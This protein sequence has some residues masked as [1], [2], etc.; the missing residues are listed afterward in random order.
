MNTRKVKLFKSA[1]EFI[2]GELCFTHEEF[3]YAKRLA[4]VKEPDD[5]K[6]FWEGITENKLINYQWSVFDAFPLEMPEP[7][8]KKEHRGSLYEYVGDI[9]KNLKK[10]GLLK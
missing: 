7:P 1:S 3:N 6:S 5:Q 2:P 9:I 4:S 10:S 8:P